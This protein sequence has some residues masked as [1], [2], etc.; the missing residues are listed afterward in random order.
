LKDKPYEG[1]NSYGPYFMWSIEHEGIEKAFFG[2]P[3]LNAQ[4]SEL[5]LSAGDT[6]SLKKIPVQNG[7]KLTSKIVLEVVARAHQIVP[8][9]HADNLKETMRQC[10]WLKQLKSRGASQMCLSR[11]TM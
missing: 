10:F 7:R 1:T 8:Q 4:I 3:E 9:A 5:K 6:I 2:T 11:T